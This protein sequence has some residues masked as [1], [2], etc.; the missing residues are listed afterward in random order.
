MIN[1]LNLFGIFGCGGIGD[2]VGMGDEKLGVFMWRRGNA[3]FE[4]KLLSA[5]L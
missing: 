1:G 2:V 4:I 5:F 3:S